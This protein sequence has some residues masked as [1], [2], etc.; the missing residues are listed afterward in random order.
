MF[1]NKITFY[2]KMNIPINN[3]NFVFSKTERDNFKNS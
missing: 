2:H 1:N 3:L